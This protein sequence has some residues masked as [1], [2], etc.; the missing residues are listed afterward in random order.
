MVGSSAQGQRF[1][2][3]WADWQSHFSAIFGIFSWFDLY[4]DVV[5][6]RL[7]NFNSVLAKYGK[8]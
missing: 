5:L 2:Q 6:P 1:V 3:D 8:N 7:E 4:V